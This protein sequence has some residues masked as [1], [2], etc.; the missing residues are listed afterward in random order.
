MKNSVKKAILWNLVA[1]LVFVILL[2]LP[3]KSYGEQVVIQLRWKHQFQ[4]AGY[5]M[6]LE[7]GYYKEAN[8]DVELRTVTPGINII[9]EVLSQRAQFG[10]GCTGLLINRL[11]GN[12]VVVV[13]TI[14]QHSPTIFMALVESGIKTLKDF[15][16]KKVM[17][18]SGYTSSS[19]VALL[20]KEGLIDKIQ[21]V[22]T[23]FDVHS[24]ITGEADVFNA[25]LSNEPE[26]LDGL[27]RKYVII[28]PRDYGLDFYGDALFTSQNFLQESPDAVEKIRIATIKGW[29]YAL[30]HPE[31]TIKVIID[32]WKSTSSKHHLRFEA[33]V[34]REMIS[35]D[36]VEIGYSNYSRWQKMAKQLKNA[37]IVST[38]QVP[39]D[40]VYN[41][42][43][44]LDWQKIAPWMI[45]GLLVFALLLIFSIFV[46]NA[47][48]RLKKALLEVKTL[49]GLVPICAT[50]KK[51][52][53]DKGYWKILES[54]LM[55][56]THAT[57]SHGICPSCAEQ[58]Y[59][60]FYTSKDS[61]EME[62]NQTREPNNCDTCS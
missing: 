30:D 13:S 23:S 43:K 6:A 19:L 37:G 22:V 48:L 36:I 62:K 29:Q 42:E 3:Q 50:C 26:V 32:K 21:R 45:G 4:F 2:V 10:I 49:S 52:R 56:N 25:Y 27:K 47:N 59:P 12:K 11:S 20:H 35:S 18:H 28:N 46:V 8:L 14:F 34:I 58:F 61:Q 31:E 16:N 40:F 39:L 38:D 51:I 5:Y 41:P 24:L 33:N 60:E 53:N 54:Y 57:F 17:I 9:D 55:E 1:Y 44:N 15:V 7:K